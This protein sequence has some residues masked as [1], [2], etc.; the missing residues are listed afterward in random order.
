MKL[1]LRI[2]RFRK[3]CRTR[4]GMCHISFSFVLF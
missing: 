3:S 1:E 2:H 4:N